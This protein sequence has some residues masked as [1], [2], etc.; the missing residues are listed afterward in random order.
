MFTRIGVLLVGTLLGF[1]L[2]QSWMRGVEAAATVD[3]LHLLGAGSVS[4]GYQAS[5]VVGSGTHGEF[6][7]V[8]TAPCS[9][10]ASLLALA[11]LAVLRPPAARGRLALAVVA[12]MALVFL[13]NIAR[14]TASVGVGLLVGPSALVLFHDWVGSLFA[15]AYTLGG[16]LVMMWLLLPRDGVA[17]DDLCLVSRSAGVRRES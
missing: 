12:A 10:L 3:V 9:S 16:F 11:G 8:L 13:G 6:A 2:L 7:A 15:F 1:A 17:L 14:I 5:I 4:R